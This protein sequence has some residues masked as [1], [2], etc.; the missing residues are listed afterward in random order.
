MMDDKT[1]QKAP[2]TTQLPDLTEIYDQFLDAFSLV[3]CAVKTLY[4]Y[5]SEQDE[6]AAIRAL[7]QGVDALSKVSGRLR[8][9]AAMQV[10]AF[11][12]QGVGKR[13]TP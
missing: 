5:Q 8:E 6:R 2:T 1:A 3:L 13:G 4:D 12:K 11:L 10:S 9:A 7:R